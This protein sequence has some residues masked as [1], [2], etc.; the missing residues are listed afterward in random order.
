MWLLGFELWTFRRAVSVF[1][2]WAISPAPCLYF[3]LMRVHLFLHSH[4]HYPSVLSEL[5][6]LLDTSGEQKLWDTRLQESI[7]ICGDWRKRHLGLGEWGIA[8]QVKWWVGVGQELVHNGRT[9]RQKKLL[10]YE[11]LRLSSS[12]RLVR[13]A[14]RQ[15]STSARWDWREKAG[16]AGPGAGP[17]RLHVR[18]REAKGIPCIPGL[19]NSIYERPDGEQRL[20]SLSWQIPGK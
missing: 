9:T 12:A 20:W 13:W 1:A 6:C 18:L 2:H 3:L 11:A 5:S 16:R 10:L 14:G 19:A 15:P 7:W 17:Y 8:P 4:H